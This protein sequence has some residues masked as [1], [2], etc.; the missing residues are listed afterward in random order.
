MDTRYWGPSGWRLLHLISFAAKTLPQKDVCEFFNVVPYVLPCKWCR[1]SLS[2]YMQSDPAECQA[3]MS[4]WL[5]RIHNDVNDKLRGQHLAAEP[6]PSFASVKNIYEARLAAPCT[7]TV[8]DGWEFLFSVAESHPMSA[9]GRVSEPIGDTD[10]REP[11]E[12][13]RLN[14]MTPEERLPHYIRF[15]QLLPKVLPFSEW[16]SAATCAGAQWATRQETLKTLWSMRCTMEE[17]LELL[18]RTSFS[19]LCKE[20]K[21]YRSGCSASRRGKTCRRKR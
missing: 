13:N 7:R 17:K 6:N 1:K 15:W 2:E 14:V 11:L 4:K 18:N 8:F 16:R 12:R 10:S 20:L 21:H 9:A 5:W 3:D 19:S